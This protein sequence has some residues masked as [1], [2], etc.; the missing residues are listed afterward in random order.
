ME[1]LV[2]HLQ[3]SQQNLLAVQGAEQVGLASCTQAAHR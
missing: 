3:S 2:A 1:A